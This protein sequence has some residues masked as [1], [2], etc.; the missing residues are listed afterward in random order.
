MLGCPDLVYFAI[1][2]FD[3]IGNWSL[4]MMS[5]MSEGHGAAGHIEG[6]L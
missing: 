1:L 3:W 2:P 5:L 4:A 6:A